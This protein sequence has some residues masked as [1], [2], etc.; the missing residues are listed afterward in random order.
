LGQMGEQLPM[1]ARW[2]G[3]GKTRLPSHV[4]RIQE[5]ARMTWPR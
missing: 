5:F 2:R 4:P 3:H 1:L